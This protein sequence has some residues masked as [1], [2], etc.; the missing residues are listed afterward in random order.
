M[1]KIDLKEKHPNEFKKAIEFDKQIRILP[2]FN[3]ENYLHRSLKPLSEVVF[4]PKNTSD[5]LD[6]M[7]YMQN[8]CEGM[9]GL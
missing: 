2:K 7:S 9:C 1:E 4:K 8:E 5:Q 3:N 6:I